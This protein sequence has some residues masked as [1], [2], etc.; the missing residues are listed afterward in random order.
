MRNYLLFLKRGSKMSII[1]LWSANI[2]MSQLQVGLNTS[3]CS[4]NPNILLKKTEARN[5]DE[6]IK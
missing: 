6:Y 1:F 3:T 2:S 5:Y 4:C